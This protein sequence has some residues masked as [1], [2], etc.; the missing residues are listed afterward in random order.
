MDDLINKLSRLVPSSS[1]TTNAILQT[2]LNFSL[3]LLNSKSYSSVPASKGDGEGDASLNLNGSGE[4]SAKSD[5]AVRQ[6]VS[7]STPD[8]LLEGGHVT[9][10]Y[11]GTF[12]FGRDGKSDVKFR[13]LNRIL[14]CGKAQLCKRVFGDALNESR[15]PDRGGSNR[16][17]SR[18][19]LK[20]SNLEWAF[21]TLTEHGDSTKGLFLMGYS[22]ASDSQVSDPQISEF[23]TGQFLDV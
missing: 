18:L 10:G 20:H 6:S 9:V 16:Y 14:I 2:P 12:A 21:D 4:D 3:P 11:R 22:Q 5:S 15:D 8:P 1:T 13:K 19:Y 23:P 17:T 7:S